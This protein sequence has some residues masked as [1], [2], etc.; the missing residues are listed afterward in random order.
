M[1]ITPGKFYCTSTHKILGESTIPTATENTNI[2]QMRTHCEKFSANH[3]MIFLLAGLASRWKQVVRYEFTSG[4]IH[5]QVFKSIIEDIIKKA[6]GIGL[7]VHAVTT[8]MGGSNQSMWKQFGI[9]ISRYS[10]IEQSTI[11]QPTIE[12]P[13]IRTFCEHPC[14]NSRRLYFFPV[15][16]HIY[17]NIKCSLVI[18]KV[19]KLSDDI[20]KKTNYHLIEL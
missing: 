2:I 17:K 13:T 8:D 5:S 19:F 4:S 18:N 7:Q 1:N 9:N 6:E 12:Q 16:V 11:E 15:A 20:V 14:D 10:T 3:A